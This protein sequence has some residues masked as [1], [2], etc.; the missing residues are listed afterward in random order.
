MAWMIMAFVIEGKSSFTDLIGITRGSPLSHISISPA[1]YAT[2]LVI[3]IIW[4]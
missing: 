2:L 3:E 4:G 1:Q